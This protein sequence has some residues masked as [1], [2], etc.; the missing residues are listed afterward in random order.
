[1]GFRIN[2]KDI[3]M[4]NI[5]NLY[6]L[7]K[8][9]MGT[10]DGYDFTADID[11]SPTNPASV[12]VWADQ[13]YVVGDWV[14]Y[15]ADATQHTYYCKQNTTSN[16]N[17]ADTDY[18]ELM[19]VSAEG[20]I[21]LGTTTGSAIRRVIN[22]YGYTV[23]NLYMNRA[24]TYCGLFGYVYTDAQLID[25]HLRDVNITNAANGCGALAGYLRDG[26]ATRCSATGVVAQSGSRQAFGGLVGFIHNASLTRSWADVNVTANTM[27]GGFV[28][29][30]A[31]SGVVISDCY[32]FGDVATTS[33]FEDTTGGFMG[34]AWQGSAISRCYCFGTVTG[35]SSHPFVGTSSL[36]ATIVDC[37]WDATIGPGNPG[38]DNGGATGK[39]TAEMQDIDTFTNTETVG[40][41]TAWDMVLESAHDG[42]Q[43]TAIWFID[44]GADYP[45]LYFEWEA[46]EEP[47]EEPTEE[48]KLYIKLGGVFVQKPIKLKSDGVF[49]P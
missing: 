45:R 25:I 43:V 36:N 7:A 24:T 46:T 3:I 31:G 22:G 47:P 5:T 21:P 8:I 18:W 35:H 20:W 44:S 14:K 28:G 6:D 34:R 16:Q 33:F 4:P 13:N 42:E 41:T 27:V 11:A 39:T 30:D 19:W 49:I 9:P 37:F 17:P 48:N 1:L 10:G 26:S 15:T 2:G 29:D 23:S 32:S 12:D 38:D 40:L